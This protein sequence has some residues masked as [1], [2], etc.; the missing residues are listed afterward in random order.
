MG[1]P[2]YTYEIACAQLCGLGH[3]KMQGFMRIQ[4]QEEFDAWMQAEVEKAKQR[5]TDDFWDQ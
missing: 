4:T 1:K 5:K 3:Y 2:G